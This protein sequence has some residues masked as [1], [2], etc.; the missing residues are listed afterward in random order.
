MDKITEWC[1]GCRVC[2]GVCPKHC[3]TMVA[4]EEGF[5]SATIDEDSCINCGLCVK[6][7]PQNR[8]DLLHGNVLEVWAARLRDE[9]V[10][11]RSA[12]GGAFAGMALRVLHEGGVV[13][14]VRWN[15]DY[16]AIHCKAE[17]EQ[18]LWPLLSSK[19]VQSDTG[20]TFGEVKALLQGGR[21]VL[22]SGTGCQ[23]AG[24]K[25]YL[26]KS[27][28]NLITI[29]L[30]CHGVTSPL[31][32]QK[33]I[34]LLSHKHEARIEEYD[35]RDKSGGWGLG[36][37]YK[38][39]YKYKY[40]ISSLSPYYKH[41]LDGDAYRMC[42]Y[43]CKYASTERCGDITIADYWGIERC[44][45]DFFDTKG[46]SL[47]LV[48]SEK[49]KRFWQA[50]GEDFKTQKSKLEY[51]TKENHNLKY[52]TYLDKE[53]RASVYEGIGTMLPEE[54]FS[55][56]LPIHPSVLE[57]FKGILPM[58]AKLWLKKLSWKVKRMR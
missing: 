5:L 2:E 16:K 47:V 39:K 52:P 17:T 19:Y 35:F 40:G 44:H 6:R 18:E 27:Y 28:D 46:V 23:I 3:I 41:F 10:L 53:K 20:S 45:P 14:G 56:R 50:S 7:C 15:E 37:K 31:L 24:L 38:Y 43:S 48:N 9:Q 8:G 25:S 33:Y 13:Y 11:R 29:D 49:G 32:F 42:C 51:A 34:E 4:D 21:K 55:K 22:Y 57:H 36:Y 58:K 1:T 30:V 12:S 54:Y 26:N